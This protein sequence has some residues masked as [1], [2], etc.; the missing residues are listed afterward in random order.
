MIIRKQQFVN[1][2]STWPRNTPPSTEIG[3]LLPLSEI[4]HLHH[5]PGLRNPLNTLEVFYLTA[6]SF[7]EYM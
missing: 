5:Y 4:F 1:L 7:A 3:G 6:L 2:L